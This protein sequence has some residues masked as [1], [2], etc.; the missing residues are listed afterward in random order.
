MSNESRLKAQHRAWKRLRT[1]IIIQV[2]DDGTC[3]LQCPEHQPWDICRISQF[4]CK[5]TR[6]LPMLA[7]EMC[8]FL[9]LKFRKQQ[10]ENRRFRAA[11]IDISISHGPYSR[12]PLKHAKR[13]IKRLRAVAHGALHYIGD[14]ESDSDCALGKIGGDHEF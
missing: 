5:P 11:L 10:D 3:S 8:P 14:I 13:Y 1:D 4:S 7:G 2:N 9:V 6:K 12:D